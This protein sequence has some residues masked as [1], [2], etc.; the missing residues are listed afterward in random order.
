MSVFFTDKDKGIAVGADGTIVKTVNGGASWEIISIEWMDVFPESVIA[1]G[2][3]S[4]NLYD[5]FFQF[6]N[7]FC[8]NGS[9]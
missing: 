8:S 5:V 9:T 1:E 2:I 7:E 6:T 3:V 4:V